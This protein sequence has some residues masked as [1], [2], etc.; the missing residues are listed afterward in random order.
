MVV[1]VVVVVVAGG[2][3]DLHLVGSPRLQFT[4]RLFSAAT[5]YFKEYCLLTVPNISK[6]Q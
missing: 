4:C 5:I 6:L 2:M 1:V 3:N